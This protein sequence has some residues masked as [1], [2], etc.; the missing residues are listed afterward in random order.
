MNT[1][2]S[3]KYHAQTVKDLSP[4]LRSVCQIMGIAM[5]EVE[6][7]PIDGGGHHWTME[8]TVGMVRV[9]IT[10]FI[11]GLDARLTVDIPD[12]VWCSTGEKQGLGQCP[13]ITSKDH[14]EQDLCAFCA[15]IVRA[16][17]AVL[18]HT[19]DRLRSRE[20]SLATIGAAIQAR[21]ELLTALATVE[22]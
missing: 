15:W 3:I 11:R 12:L 21:Q 20:E 1:T 22:K 16:V 9:L 5:A 2:V 18:N 13:R 10:D 14:S 7:Y 4:R 19:K 6:M 8:F 17:Q